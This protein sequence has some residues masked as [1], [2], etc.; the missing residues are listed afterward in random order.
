MNTWW[1]QVFR[2][3][4]TASL[5]LFLINFFTKWLTG[6]PLQGYA[7]STMALLLVC[8]LLIWARLRD[9]RAERRYRYLLHTDA[10]N[11]TPKDF[12]Y[13]VQHILKDL[14]WQNVYVVGRA[15]IREWILKPN[16]KIYPMPYSVNDIRIMLRQVWCAILLG[17]CN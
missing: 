11:L 10:L 9:Y 3:F 17:Q 4:L 8:V 7:I 13:R 15:G 14:G 16:I 1:S 12:E 5:L 6:Y 2:F